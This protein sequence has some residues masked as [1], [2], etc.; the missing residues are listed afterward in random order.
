MKKGN[1]FRNAAVFI[2][3]ALLCL[4]FYPSATFAGSGEEIVDGN[5]TAF[6]T[7]TECNVVY[8]DNIVTFTSPANEDEFLYFEFVADEI[9][10]DPNIMTILW[11]L[12]YDADDNVTGALDI[13]ENVVYNSTGLGTEYMVAAIQV[14]G[15]GWPF[16]FDVWSQKTAGFD[17]QCELHSWRLG[18]YMLWYEDEN[19]PLP[20]MP[21]ETHEAGETFNLPKNLY[22][23]PIGY[24][25]LG[26]SEDIST[27]I[28]TYL[29][30]GIFTMPERDVHLY[31]VWSE[32]EYTVTYHGNGSD[33]DIADIISDGPYAN[34]DYVIV[35]GN[36][37]IKTGSTFVEW[38]TK[39]DGTGITYE[40]GSGF[41]IPT[42]N[43]TLYA[44][45]QEVVVPYE[46]T[47]IA[48]TDLTA[49]GPYLSG[50]VVD[51]KADPPDEGKRFKQWTTNN[52]GS[53]ANINSPTTKFTM[54]KGDVTVTAVYENQNSQNS[55]TFTMFLNPN[56]PTTAL[57]E[58]VFTL[59]SGTE[60][61][62]TSKNVT[63]GKKYG[64]L[65]EPKLSGHTFG[66]WYREP[67][68][69]TKVTKD[70]MHNV[71]ENVTLYAKWTVKS[72]TVTFNANGGKFT[73]IKDKPK[74]TS[75][76]VKTGSN[77][78]LPAV[79]TRVGRTFAGWYY[80]K[81]ATNGPVDSTTPLDAARLK[82]HTLYAK[83]TGDI[84][85]LTFNANG[86]QFDGG[87]PPTGYEMEYG[88]L[89]NSASYPLPIA[90]PTITQ[91][92]KNLIFRGWALSKTGSVV[93]GKKWSSALS[94]KQKSSR[95]VTLYAIWTSNATIR[96][97]SNGGTTQLNGKNVNSK[98][99]STSA[100][101]YG[102]LPKSTRVGHIFTGWY[103]SEDENFEN[104]ITSKT[105]LMFD[106]L[107]VEQSLYA[108][109]L[110]AGWTPKLYKIT[111]NKNAKAAT[112]NGQSSIK[113]IE[114]GTPYEDVFDEVD[115]EPERDGYVFRGW[116][117]SKSA[118]KPINPTSVVKASKTLYARWAIEEKTVKLN[119][120]GGK[121]IN[122][123]GNKVSTLSVKDLLYLD[124][125]DLPEPDVDKA[126]NSFVGWFTKKAGGKQITD[127]TIITFTGKSQTLYAHWT[128]TDKTVKF[129]LNGG[130]YEDEDTGKTIKTTFSQKFI[131]GEEYGDLPIPTPPNHEPELY[132]VGWFTKK[133]GGTEVIEET[134][135]TFTAKSKTLYARW[136]T[137]T[138]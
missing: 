131:W 62:S 120:N 43:L 113:N 133:I 42:S 135:L 71:S 46:L 100:K 125:Y 105:P 27:D 56:E 31:T 50:T 45:W 22:E 76:K 92:S 21:L 10:D 79:P 88:A 7:P 127:E 49:S 15:Q 137:T 57:T 51:I 28:A 81:A 12:G 77:Y 19:Y 8:E 4:C 55:Q 40:P 84:Y 85:Q 2:L 82:N 129:N 35:L 102:T 111:F 63:V 104:R 65:R 29:D 95:E 128:T 121:F 89:W 99:V 14:S 17:N 124:D 96:Y 103:D 114:Y 20:K 52:G 38:N 80:D 39:A 69:K 117:A 41:E 61:H 44:I 23:R 73:T 87:L 26:W 123:A 48:G 108:Q 25:F 68:G 9:Y 90:I 66:G 101:T 86:G 74:T 6:D 59:D 5:V 83:W 30:E 91:T 24:A 107:E 13:Q 32:P 16:I 109:T 64:A 54:P 67:S 98:S 53:F 37:F 60:V 33:G 110:V 18:G 138:E 115:E 119:A 75:K 36:S 11:A 47:I 134:E 126:K 1:K 122:D 94:S 72:Y 34:A 78:V 130:T 97:D 93:D 136:S 132:F 112:Y 116:F 118:S 106:P 3:T 70:T 58:A